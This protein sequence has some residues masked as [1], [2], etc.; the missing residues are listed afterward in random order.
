MARLP[1]EREL[2]E[3]LTGMLEMVVPKRGLDRR[4]SWVEIAKEVGI[5]ASKCAIATAMM[6]DWYQ[7]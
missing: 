5:E 2:R 3:E 4:K 6:R 1:H 7:H